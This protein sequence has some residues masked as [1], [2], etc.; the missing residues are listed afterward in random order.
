MGAPTDSNL[1]VGILMVSEHVDTLMPVTV[2]VKTLA[3][4]DLNWEDVSARLIEEAK[5]LKSGHGL[6]GRAAT[7]KNTCGVCDWTTKPTDRCL[8]NPLNPQNRLNVPEKT[9]SDIPG[10]RHV[11]REGVQGEAERPDWTLR[12]GQGSQWWPVP[13]RS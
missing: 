11:R 2:S 9:V 1:A 13:S 4:K 10:H 8:L 6:P 7:A 5:S 12:H 3:D